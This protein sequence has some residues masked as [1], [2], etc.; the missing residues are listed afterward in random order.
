VVQTTTAVTSGTVY[1]T[2]PVHIILLGAGIPII[3][4]LRGLDQLPTAGFTFS[5]VPPKVRAMGT[6]P[7]CA[8]TTLFPAPAADRLTISL[9][10]ANYGAVR[11]T[12]PP[13]G[14]PFSRPQPCRAPG[15]QPPT[16]T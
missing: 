9:R 12:P 15:T 8:Y 5:A 2:R 11:Y 1:G 13:N 10:S 16:A 14:G 3:E 7:K 6:F 4:Y